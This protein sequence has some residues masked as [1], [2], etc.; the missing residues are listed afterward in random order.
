M[1]LCIVVFVSF[2]WF[3]VAQRVPQSG[4]DPQLWACSSTNT[5]GQ[6]WGMDH[7]TFPYNHIYLVNSKVNQNNFLVLDI[8]AWANNTGAEIHMWYNNTGSQ[9]YNQQ[10]RYDTSSGQITSMMNGLCVTARASAVGMTVITGQCS[11]NNPLQ[12]FDFTSDGH[13]QL[14]SAPSFCLDVGSQA[15]CQE[16]PFSSY[17]YCNPDASIESRV[18]DLIPRLLPIDFQMLL[19]NSNPGIPR[20]GVPPVQFGECLHGTLSGCGA[21]YTDPKTGYTSTGCPTSFP[22]ILMQSTSFNRSLWSAIGTAVSTEDRALHNQQGIAASIFWAPDINEFR[23]PRWGRGQEVAGED[24][25]L[26]SEWVYHYSTSLQTGEDERY[27]KAASTAKHFSAY[28]MESSDGTWRGAFNAIVP[29]H[30]LVQYYW[31]AFRS[32]VQRAHVQSIMCSYNA[33]NGIPSCANDFFNNFIVR[34]QWQWPGFIVSDCGAIAFIQDDHHYTND[35]NATVAA[36]L[37]G[38]TDVNCGDV[39]NNYIV[40]SYANGNIN[41]TDLRIAGTR[42]LR[43]VFSLGLMDPPERVVYTKYNATMVDT[44]SHRKLAYETAIQG[45]VLL[46]NN[47]SST[48]GNKPILPLNGKALRRVAVVGPNANATQGLLSNYHG[49]N[50]LVNDHSILAGITRRGA[51]DGF[52]VNFQVG[53]WQI[54]CPTTSGFDA[55]VDA[56]KGSDVTI[57]VVGLCSDDCPDSNADND[58][59]EGEGHDRL[60]TDLPG[61]QEDL[62]RALLATGKPVVVVVVHG[63]SISMDWTVGNA[64]AILDALYPGEMGGDAITALLF[65]D[66]SPSGRVTT[67]WYT[68]NFQ[69]Q[70]N[71]TDMV[72]TPHSIGSQQIPGITYLYYDQPVLYPF[73]WG[74]SYTT[75]QYKW[76]NPVNSFVSIRASDIGRQSGDKATY[77]AVNVTNTGSVVSDVSA[78]AFFSTNLPGEPIQE[79]FDFQRAGSVQPGTTVT[80]YFSLPPEV[81]AAV[82]PDGEQVIVPGT[83]TVEIGDVHKSGNY[84]T[85]KVEITGDAQELFFVEKASCRVRATS[86]KLR[87]KGKKKNESKFVS[88]F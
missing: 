72:I 18:A 48:N 25:F 8:G 3:S 12:A 14:R 50:S 41:I 76:F 22:H 68:T 49:T 52:D 57:V 26:T 61:H 56:A 10:W 39:Y 37:R 84:V 83:Y 21:P 45:A 30:D 46:Q 4:M 7:G 29:D 74:L 36:G 87:Q 43:T 32:A 6:I 75:F 54:S 66:V 17:V 70:R 58:A 88:R 81:I 69:H 28:D 24:P 67:T 85:G 78:L 73:G 65:G 13:L 71:V 64:P 9:G 40:S 62:I 77:F 31:P 35:R 15:S 16:A 19:D 55:A 82:S 11:N 20:L 33:V 47:A 27:I 2:V 59:H 60:T 79:L 38:G 80:L 86:T 63:G 44:P 23:D 42:F 51:T 53:C 34:E 5:A 1:K